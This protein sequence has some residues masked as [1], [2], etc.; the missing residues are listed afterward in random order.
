MPKF[1]CS[2]K[3]FETNQKKGFPHGQGQAGGSVFQ[4]ALYGAGGD[5]LWL[6]HVYDKAEENECYWLMWY[7]EHGNA[8]LGA[9]TVFNK[10]DLKEMA[11]RLIKVDDDLLDRRMP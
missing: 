7:D 4:D 9:G 5:S 1:T 6:E 11:A 2:N 8:K 10:K 3:R